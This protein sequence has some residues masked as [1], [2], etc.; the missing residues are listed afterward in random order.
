MWTLH[1]PERP[2]CRWEHGQTEVGKE[3]R[4]AIRACRVAE[5]RVAQ[6]GRGWRQRGRR[7]GSGGEG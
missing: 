7:Q 5:V 1:R 3:G 4:G 6:W 2:L